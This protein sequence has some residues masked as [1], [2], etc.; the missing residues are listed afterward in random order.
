VFPNDKALEKMLFLAYSDLSK[1]WKFAI[2][3]WGKIISQLA[4]TF[5]E[6][7]KLDV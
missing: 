4:I 7:L 6:M 1:K 2:R 3:D 5:G